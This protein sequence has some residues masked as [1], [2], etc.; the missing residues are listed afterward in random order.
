MAIKI[1][2]NTMVEPIE[3]TCEFCESVFSY[4]YQDIQ[5]DIRSG[6]FGLEY[7]D[8]FITCPVCKRRLILKDEVKRL[9]GL[10]AGQVLIDEGEK[11][12]QCESGTSASD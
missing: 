3:K 2:K 9:D 5:T 8:R 6:F 11:N 12:E 10:E 7:H 4:N 1:I